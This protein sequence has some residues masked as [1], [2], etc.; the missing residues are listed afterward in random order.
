MHGCALIE[1]D[2]VAVDRRRHRRRDTEAAR[3]R[4]RIDEVVMSD[5]AVERVRGRGP[6]LFG[7]AYREMRVARRA[8]GG[9]G[10]RGLR[11]GLRAVR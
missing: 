8:H 11:I 9:V 3:D 4:I 1:R 6:V 7:S 5:H 10:K 2:A